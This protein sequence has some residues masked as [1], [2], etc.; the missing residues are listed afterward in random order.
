MFRHI[1]YREGRKYKADGRRK[2]AIY[3][4]CI[5]N[6]QFRVSASALCAVFFGAVACLSPVWCYK[7]IPL[8]YFFYFIIIRIEFSLFTVVCN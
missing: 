3:I 6:A 7:R 1:L 5:A 8:K 2:A 4:N